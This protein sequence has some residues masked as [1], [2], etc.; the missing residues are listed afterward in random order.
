MDQDSGVVDKFY[1]V[2]SLSFSLACA[3]THL[4]WFSLAFFFPSSLQARFPSRHL[5]TERHLFD[6]CAQPAPITVTAVT[7]SPSHLSAIALSLLL[8]S[9]WTTSQ[10]QQPSRIN[11]AHRLT[12]EAAVRLSSHQSLM[13]HLCSLPRHTQLPFPCI[14]PPLLQPC[15]PPL[16]C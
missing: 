1:N 2:F 8:S 14:L 13:H 12:V 6:S 7:F 16:P 15:L 5:A 11:F 9:L 10:H 3:Y 4:L